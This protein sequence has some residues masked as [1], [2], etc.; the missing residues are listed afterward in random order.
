MDKSWKTTR[1]DFLSKTAVLAGGAAAFQI[2]P[3]RV[4]GAPNRPAPSDTIVL[5]H[6]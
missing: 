5:G 6:I 1:R 4:L 2:V 3:R